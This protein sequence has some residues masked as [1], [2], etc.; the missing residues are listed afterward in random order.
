MSKNKFEVCDRCK[1]NNLE[2]LIPKLKEVDPEAEIEVRC[3]RFCGIGRT[4][5]VVLVNHL[6]V[7]GMSEDEVID[8]IK[9]KING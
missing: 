8:K 5:I 2:T 1:A 3:I 9:E 6:P 7:I 4:K